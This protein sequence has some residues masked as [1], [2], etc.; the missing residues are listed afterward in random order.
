M[1]QAFALAFLLAAILNFINYKWLKLPSSIGNM[2]LAL[3]FALVILS[4]Q[5]VTPIAYEYTCDMIMKLDFSVLVLD[6][7]LSIL[8]FAGAMHVDLSL[9]KKEKWPV[10]AF[11]S[12]GVLIS[13]TIVGFALYAL[14][15]LLGVTLPLII[16]F[17]FGALISPTD[18]IAVLAILDKASLSDKMKLKI[19]GESLFNDGFGVVVFTSLLMFLPDDMMNDDSQNSI[20]YEVGHL[21]LL[22]VIGGISFGLFFGWLIGRMIRSIDD[23]PQHVIMLLLGFALGGYAIAQALGLSAPLT[24][25]VSGLYLGNLINDAAFNNDT[26]DV[27][28]EVW[29]I[30]DK[31]LNTIL[32]VLIGIGIH[33]VKFDWSILY[34][35][36]ICILIVLISR[37][38]SISVPYALLRHKDSLWKTANILTWGGLRGGISIALALSLSDTKFGDELLLL[39]FIV[40]VFSIIVQGL[41]VGKLADRL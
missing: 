33:L 5:L 35:G 30:L 7:L 9:L 17:L 32:F 39:C 12:I 10:L 31:S 37:F 41:T 23:C 28:K 24:M 36:L 2:I 4:S 8:L 6:I 40:V 18:P 38:I 22:E 26:A 21:F 34:L 13:T 16:C 19:E 27:T 11:A 20:S 15:P 1:Y 29:Q 14:A 3:V 25:V